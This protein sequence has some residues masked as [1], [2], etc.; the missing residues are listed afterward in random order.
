MVEKVRYLKGEKGNSGNLEM[1]AEMLEE[2]EMF[3]PS[4]AHR[5]NSHCRNTWHNKKLFSSDFVGKMS[6]LTGNSFPTPFP[7][8]NS[9]YCLICSAR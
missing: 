9:F 3:R 6:S 4:E 5:S 2:G 1:R 7:A 8:E